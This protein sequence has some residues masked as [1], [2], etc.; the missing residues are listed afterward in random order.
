MLI[1]SLLGYTVS[2][3]TKESFATTTDATKTDATKT[4][5]TKTTATTATTAAAATDT[6]SAD[7]ILQTF[8]ILLIV[9]IVLVFV[10]SYGAAKLSWGY[11]YYVGNSWGISFFYSF[12]AFIFSEFYY[13]LYAYLLNPIYNIRK[14]R[15]S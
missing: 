10:Y 4:D 13:P 8:Y 2:K 5:A 1:L 12:L 3:S 11:N 7:S 9:Y 14:L 6:A 15:N